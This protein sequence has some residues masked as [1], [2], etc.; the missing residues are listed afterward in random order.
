MVFGR[1]FG[2]SN[3]L[4]GCLEEDLCLG[5]GGGGGAGSLGVSSLVLGKTAWILANLAGQRRYQAGWSC[6]QFGHFGC[7]SCPLLCFWMQESVG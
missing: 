6:L 3:C 4:G 2:F 7:V 1:F 5:G